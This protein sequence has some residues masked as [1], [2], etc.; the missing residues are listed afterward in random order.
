MFDKGIL[1]FKTG[2]ATAGAVLVMIGSL[3]FVALTRKVIRYDRI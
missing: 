2:L 1:N 3:A